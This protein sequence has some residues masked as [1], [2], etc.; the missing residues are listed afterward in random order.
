VAALVLGVFFAVVDRDWGYQVEIPA[1][2]TEL[3]TADRPPE[4]LR[5]WID[6]RSGRLVVVS[7]VSGPSEDPPL[8]VV[9]AGIKDKAHGYRRLSARK[10]GLGPGRKAKVPGW[11]LWFR[12][13]RDGK[14]V[15]MGARFLF[16]KSYALSIL[17]DVPGRRGP[18]AEARRIVES[19]LPPPPLP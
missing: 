2:W 17:V 12:L 9:E 8:R 13:E 18:S 19:F 10:R 6:E 4:V 14:P 1:G 16:Y 5:G 7:R 3:S 11:D 15:T